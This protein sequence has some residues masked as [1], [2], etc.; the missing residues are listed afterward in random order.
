MENNPYRLPKTVLPTRY[1]LELVPDLE[2]FTYSGVADIQLVVS[3]PT[4]R[5]TLNADEIT[6]GE[7][8]VQVGEERITVTAVGLDAETE[9]AHLSVE[10]KVAAGDATL[11][12]EFSGEINDELR[13]FYRSSYT[14]GS[15]EHVLGTTQMQPTDAR[16]AF[17]CWDE[18]EF[19]AVFG[20]TLVVPDGV[21][22]VANGPEESTEPLGEGIRRV[23]FAD[24]MPMSTYLTAWTMGRLEATEPRMVDGVPVRVVHVPGKENLT[25]FALDIAEHSL[26]FF[27]DY[28]GIPYPEKKLDLIALPD[29][30]AGAMENP[31]CV[32]FREAA[33]LVDPT[34][35]TQ[36]ERGRIADTTAHEIAHMWFGDLVTMSWWNGTWL[37]EAFATFMALI[38]VDSW[39]PEWK[40]FESFALDRAES[41]DV[42]ALAS[43]RSIEF[44]VVAPADVEDM[45][46]VLTYEKGGSVLWM[47]ERYLGRE[48]FRDGIRKYLSDNLYGNTD[49]T[50]L[51]DALEEVTGKPV[52]RV[53]DAWIWQG[54]HP[55][56]SAALQD[57]RV[58]L[59]QKRFSY[60]PVEERAWPTPLH[61]RVG[62]VEAALLL[63]AEGASI[64]APTDGSAVVVNSGGSS[65]VR[66]AYEG[67]LFERIASSLGEL[68]GL[69]RFAL[70]DDG[71]AAVLDGSVSAVDLCR[72]LARFGDETETPVWREI[73]GTLAT[74]DRLVE[75]EAR[76]Q[77]REF[78]RR[79]AGPALD[80]IGWDPRDGEGDLDR[81]LRGTLVRALGVLARD[82]DVIARAVEVEA[83]A[84]AGEPVEGPLA[85]AAVGVAASV[86][87][88]ALRRIY[89]DLYRDGATPQVQRRY[90]TGLAMFP[91]QSQIERSL[92]LALDGYVRSQDRFSLVGPCIASRDHGVFAWRFTKSHWEKLTDQLTAHLR[93]YMIE[94]VR[95]FSTP[96][97]RDDVVTFFGENPIPRAEKALEH[98]LERLDVSVSLREREA[99]NLQ[100][101]FAPGGEFD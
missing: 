45:F 15:G 99:S 77:L 28:Y 37:N 12:I 66:V 68:S 21:F 36:T 30:A 71:W 50:D 78:V 84:R 79:L 63:E 44:E 59:S 22:V 13:G 35:S 80:R 88:E 70:V 4:D 65:Y 76:D 39:K 23:R 48:P 10:R 58:R 41:F 31:G 82:G 98:V 55:L 38:C 87:D 93:T 83:R 16:R 90:L 67:E 47:L 9:R 1:D 11:H 19:K 25:P 91:E 46:D 27:T 86:G 53:M 32:T 73:I 6:F 101:A 33:L 74:I 89:A 7:A 26:R 20:L 69:E 43:T 5:I 60:G 54:G 72:L 100:A 42:D 17:P 94:P 62:G 14:D 34:A 2:S 24:T 85:S 95:Q 49:T 57:G 64:A 96:E 97:L 61:V 40:I 3:E 81:E 56:V 92:Q 75:G 51:W 8:W 18:P 52:R 29:F